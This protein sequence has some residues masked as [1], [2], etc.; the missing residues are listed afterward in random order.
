MKNVVL[1]SVRL[2]IAEGGN[3]DDGVWKVNRARIRP[4]VEDVEEMLSPFL[5]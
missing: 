3:R 5:G 2:I 1:S 4:V